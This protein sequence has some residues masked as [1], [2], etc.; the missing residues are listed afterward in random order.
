MSPMPRQLSEDELK[1]VLTAAELPGVISDPRVQTPALMVFLGS[2][3]ALAAV[4][5]C[6][7]MLSLSRRDRRRV[8]LVYIDTDDVPAEMVTFRDGHQGMFQEFNLR[9]A[10]PAGSAFATLPDEPLHTYIPPKDPQ[11]FSNGAG[12][13]RNNGHIAA[14]FDYSRIV[15]TLDA[16][17]SAIEKIEPAS[18]EERVREIQ[19]N[20][21]AFLGGGT[22]SGIIG[23]VAVIVRQMLATR[24]YQ[25]RLN[26]FCMLPESIDGA[27][28][29]DVSWRKSNATACLLEL[30][31]LSLATAAQRHTTNMRDGYDGYDGHNGQHAAH[32]GGY[33]K[34]LLH[35]SHDLTDDP[36]A[37]EVYLVG[38]TGTGTARDSAR[39]VGID[40]FQRLTDHS[41]VGQLEHSTWVNRRSLGA[42]DDRLLPTMFGTSC[43]LEVLFPARETAHA[44]AQVAAS[45]LLPKLVGARPD[46]VSLSS[47]DLAT[48]KK[49]WAKVARLVSSRK[50]SLDVQLP[51]EFSEAEFEQVAD[52][53]FPALQQD[54]EQRQR[55]TDEQISSMV[56]RKRVE[57]EA[58]LLAAPP[59][60]PNLPI[61][62]RH[63]IYLDSLCAEYAAVRESHEK[64]PPDEEPEYPQA[65][66]DDYLRLP[67]V[68]LPYVGVRMLQRKEADLCATF[69]DML[70]LHV[71]A[72]RHHAIVRLLQ[73]LQ[74]QAEKRKAD[75]AGFY[76]AEFQADEQSA[77]LRAA[78]LVSA[79]WR[80]K[81]EQ[82]HLHIRHVFDLESQREATIGEEAEA[83]QHMRN[84]AVEHLFF[85]ATTSTSAPRQIAQEH[86]VEADI[87]ERFTKPCMAYLAKQGAQTAS[88]QDVDA[89]TV[90]ALQTQG[91]SRLANQ[92]VAFFE[93]YYLYGFAETRATQRPPFPGFTR[94][95][96]FEL[97]GVGCHRNPQAN[98]ATY[99]HEQL[100]GIRNLMEGLIGFEETLWRGGPQRLDTTV[101]LS[102]R[103]ETS[104]QRNMLETARQQLGALTPRNQKPGIANMR[105]PHR[106]QV[107]Y[108]QHG[109]SLASMP[110]FYRD[111]MSMMG[112][113]LLNEGE[114]FGYQGPERI[115]T[116]PAPASYGANKMPPHNCAETE[117]LVCSATALGYPAHLPHARSYGTSLRGRV[118]REQERPQMAS[119]WDD[120]PTAPPDPGAN[121]PVQPPDAN[122]QSRQ[123]PRYGPGRGDL[124]DQ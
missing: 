91:K 19:A 107:S 21:V 51:K 79:A 71:E 97:L 24:L 34:Y 69:N 31:A 43:P 104:D 30:L 110:D 121:R 13:I 101:Y 26:L 117:R 115:L 14:A 2:T 36:I 64:K 54:L 59:S 12:N 40:L 1:N 55:R 57:E 112:D 16:A 72:T 48:R 74:Q 56:E 9:I 46:P 111:R 77:N 29:N 60:D 58:R 86:K 98:V 75:V 83:S 95:T 99:L 92:V 122:D 41:G 80:G 96:L 78:G 18:G 70:R 28:D 81:L 17:L 67:W 100:S 120:A 85:W 37:N 114:W 22:G 113:Y 89:E 38:R 108:G 49:E 88:G 65:Q 106:L 119:S 39:I 73:D 11:Y 66:I 105:D 63:L 109:I 25:Q 68:R 20:V 27:S 4:E 23:D 118:I 93:D 5:L 15:Q 103:W 50:D 62:Q 8:A 84:V 3:P 45:Y 44:F 61:V 33:R 94:M 82:E 32:A 6:E 90:D 42:T 53:T 87:A 102:I 47:A 7:Q 116:W 76:S 52:T 123:R 35:E 10:V 124:F